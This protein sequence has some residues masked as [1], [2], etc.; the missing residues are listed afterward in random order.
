MNRNDKSLED[1]KWYLRNGSPFCMAVFDVPTFKKIEKVLLDNDFSWIGGPF[2]SDHKSIELPSY[3]RD[4]MII[5]NFFGKKS[6][7]CEHSYHQMFGHGTRNGFFGGYKKV[8]IFLD[9]N[10]IDY[11]IRNFSTNIPNYTPKKIIKSL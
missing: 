8:D 4:I 9:S 2:R 3:T 1:L 6:L 7:L 10:N 5:G 11:I